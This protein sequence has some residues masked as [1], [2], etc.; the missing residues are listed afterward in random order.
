[1]KIAYFNL[2]CGAAGDMILAS[3]VDSG[4]SLDSLKA[5]LAKIP[6]KGYSIE[7]KKVTRSHLAATYLNIEIEETHSHRGLADIEKII[8]DSGLKD[9]VKANAKKIFGKLAIAE[10]KVHGETVETV[11]F[12]EV[13]MVDAI[14]DICGA[15]IAFDM[16]GIEK[17]YCSPL[18]I[19]S[20]TVNTQHGVMPVPAP[21]TAELIKGFPVKQTEITQEILT[22]TGAAI[23]T[24]MADFSPVPSYMPENSGYG[25]GT[26][27]FDKLPNLLRLIIG[28]TIEDIESDEINLLE[29]NLDRT[30]PEH[31]G[32]LMDRLLKAGALDVFIT[33]I[34]MKK[35]RPG[36]ML[37]VICDDE[38]ESKITDIIFSSGVTLG[39]RKGRVKRNILPRKEIIVPTKY[40]EF[41]VKLASYEGKVLYFP[42]Y[43]N[44]AEAAALSGSSFDDIYFEI[45]STLRKE[46]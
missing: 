43:D 35:N 45:I 41:S 16:L 6:L 20:G 15:A 36:Q 14:I 13:G 11:H 29:T 22:P 5:E 33:P 21:A 38:R 10:A 26:R 1:M 18:T 37:S 8:D 34:Q 7:E 3:L 46:K 28:N 32:Y 2:I 25:S 4:L 12:H 31:I 19:G 24:T 39:I 30:S 40:G 42:E 23:L 44:V 9:N 17:I 27:E